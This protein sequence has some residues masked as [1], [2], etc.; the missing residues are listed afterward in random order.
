MNNHDRFA[1]FV[2]AIAITS[3]CFWIWLA[4]MLIG[5]ICLLFGAISAGNTVK[6][7]KP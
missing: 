6:E 1:I 3:D 5:G 4:Y 2:L 7:E